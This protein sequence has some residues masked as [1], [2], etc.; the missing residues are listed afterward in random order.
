M[1]RPQCHLACRGTWQSRWLVQGAGIPSALMT[2]VVG[3]VVSGGKSIFKYLKQFITYALT[4]THTD[5]VRK[6]KRKRL[7]KRFSLNILQSS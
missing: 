2:S 3:L 6:K 1:L 4:G 7:K 5:H